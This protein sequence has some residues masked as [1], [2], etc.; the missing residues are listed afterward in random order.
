MIKI[1][2]GAVLALA[3]VAAFWFVTYKPLDYTPTSTTENNA[4]STSEG[5][6][7]D[8]EAYVRQNISVLS[9]APEELGGTFFVTK[10]STKNGSGTVEYEDGHNAYTAD[11]TYES[12]A[13]GKPVVRSF[14]VRQ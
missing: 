5:R 14:I 9:P 11:F 10:I 12:D 7:M 2:I 13:E 1:I 6:Y 4:T 3:V 8:I